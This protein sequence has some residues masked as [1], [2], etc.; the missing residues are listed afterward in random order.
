MKVRVLVEAGR[1]ARVGTVVVGCL[2]VS[3]VTL[4]TGKRAGSR[5]RSSCGDTGLGTVGTIV[6]M[7][8]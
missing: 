8:R 5:G 1:V 3:V 2:Q 6:S 4:C 7:A